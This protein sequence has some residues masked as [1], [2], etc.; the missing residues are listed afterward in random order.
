MALTQRLR[1]E[2][3]ALCNASTMEI[4]FALVSAAYPT[5]QDRTDPAF[6][7]VLC[8]RKASICVSPYGRSAFPR[9][10]EAGRPNFLPFVTVYLIDVDVPPEVV[11]GSTLIR[12][13]SVT[14]PHLTGKPCVGSK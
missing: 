13:I 9:P 6:A 8:T 2:R 11:L 14:A 12:L 1:K 3:K 5:P 7:V 10:T 4:R